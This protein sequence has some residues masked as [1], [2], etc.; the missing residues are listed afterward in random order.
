MIYDNMSE[1]IKYQ[2][3]GTQLSDITLENICGAEGVAPVSYWAPRREEIQRFVEIA[4]AVHTGEGRPRILDVGCGTGFLAYLLAETGEVDV[5]GLDPEQSL[6]QGSPYSHSNLELE[7]GDSNDAVEKYGVQD[8]DI[9]L[10]SWMHGGLNL[11]PDIRNIGAKAIIYIKEREATGVPDYDY[12]EFIYDD[13][14]DEWDDD[15]DQHK[16]PNPISSENGISYH[17]GRDYQRAFE[18]SGPACSEVQG[19]GRKLKD[20]NAYVGI[21]RDLN[22]I[23]IQFRR[24]VQIPEIPEMNI[25]DSDKYAWE[26]ALERFKGPVDEMKRYEEFSW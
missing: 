18:W 6:I 26:A 15:A 17:P 22:F 16:R 4:K 1:H 21:D 23:D 12:K 7:V 5:I 11:T 3:N 24:D 2:M 25:P 20:P 10:N 9:V 19:L 8:F 13:G 14:F